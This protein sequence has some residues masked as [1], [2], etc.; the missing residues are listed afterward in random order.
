MC[1][2]WMLMFTVT[3]FNSRKNSHTRADRKQVLT[4]LTFFSCHLSEW[5]IAEKKWVSGTPTYIADKPTKYETKK[6]ITFC[7]IVA[8]M[9]CLSFRLPKVAAISHGR[10][11]FSSHNRTWQKVPSSYS[12]Q[13]QLPTAIKTSSLT[14]RVKFWPSTTTSQLS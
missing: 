5:L 10:N 12:T 3:T 8:L 1:V 2:V 6:C 14:V 4:F 13:L 7:S 9:W 11:S